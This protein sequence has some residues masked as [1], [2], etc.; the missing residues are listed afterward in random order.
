MA[1]R[2]LAYFCCIIFL[3]L[4]KVERNVTLEDLYLN[5]FLS[6]E[7]LHLVFVKSH[8]SIYVDKK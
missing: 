8:T 5:T 4:Y 3:V 1:Y 6:F 2:R 7:I